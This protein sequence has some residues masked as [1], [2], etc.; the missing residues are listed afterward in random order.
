MG[1]SQLIFTASEDDG[2]VQICVELLEG[3]LGTDISL[4][5][6]FADFTNNTGKKLIRYSCIWNL[7]AFSYKCYVY[8]CSN[9]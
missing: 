6:Q 5:I 4:L 1:F 2:F 7:I 3:E 9:L 8:S